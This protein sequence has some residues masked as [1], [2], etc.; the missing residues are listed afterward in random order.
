ML[1]RLTMPSTNSCALTLPSLRGGEDAEMLAPPQ[2]P[3]LTLC[4]TTKHPPRSARLDKKLDSMNTLPLLLRIYLTIFYSGFTRP[5]QE[6]DDARNLL[7][8]I[9]RPLAILCLKFAPPHQNVDDANILHSDPHDLLG[10]NHHFSPPCLNTTQR[11]YRPPTEHSTRSHH[12]AMQKKGEATPEVRNYS[13]GGGNL[14]SEQYDWDY[15]TK[16]DSGIKSSY[17]IPMRE[18]ENCHQ[19]VLL[20]NED[21]CRAYTPGSRWPTQFHEDDSVLPLGQSFNSDDRSPA[22]TAVFTL[23]GWIRKTGK[24]RFRREP[25]EVYLLKGTLANWKSALGAYDLRVSMSPENMRYL[26]RLLNTVFF[27]DWIAIDEIQNKNPF[28]WLRD[29]DYPHILA[30]C[31]SKDGLPTIY[32]H[33]WRVEVSRQNQD[34]DP[35][36][37][38][39]DRLG[40]LLHELCHAVFIPY[41]DPR[42][43]RWR[44][45]VGLEG[46][47]VSWQ[48]LAKAVEEAAHSILGYKVS[49][50]YSEPPVNDAGRHIHDDCEPALGSLAVPM[51]Q[52]S[53]MLFRQ[54]LDKPHSP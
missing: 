35:S 48:I 29:D 14:R 6:A 41:F 43:S 24:W 50:G 12:Y 54:S 34:I 49:L 20:S 25:E 27:A 16:S 33:P 18:P 11:M 36:E 10:H 2:S 26:L 39:K 21:R 4:S 30:M 28:A 38:I 1:L 22:A 8:Y 40:S 13:M 46:H 37:R 23:V 47:G 32:L 5:H 9:H 31:S 17:A 7:V 53:Q 51:S 19:K 15:S 42:C 52:G 45:E 3:I 44:R